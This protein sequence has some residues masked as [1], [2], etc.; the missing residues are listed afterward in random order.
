[1]NEELFDI[2]IVALLVIWFILPLI[3]SAANLAIHLVMKRRIHPIILFFLTFLAGSATFYVSFEL[4]EYATHAE[5][6]QY[7]LNGDGFVDQSE[8][9]DEYEAAMDDWASDA[10]GSLAPAL[11]SVLTGCWYSVVF[12]TIW[13]PIEAIRFFNTLNSEALNRH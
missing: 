2:A 4:G 9:T 3:T 6:Q 13:I 10:S 12:A 11:I 5:I 1:M 8:K 7:D